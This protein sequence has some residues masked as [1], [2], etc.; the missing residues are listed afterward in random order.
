[1][2]RQ[3][4]SADA[5]RQLLVE[6]REFWDK[7]GDSR[8]VLQTFHPA[9]V[10]SDAPHPELGKDEENVLCR[11]QLPST[12]EYEYFDDVT[13][14]WVLIHSVDCPP[15]SIIS[16][17]ELCSRAGAG[18]P[19]TYTARMRPF[20]VRGLHADASSVSRWIGLLVFLKGLVDTPLA[21]EAWKRKHPD[22]QPPREVSHYLGESVTDSIRMIEAFRLHTDSP[23]SVGEWFP[24]ALEALK[25]HSR[26]AFDCVEQIRPGRNAEPSRQ[27]REQYVT[28][29]QMAA[30]ASR[31]KKTL[32]RWLKDGK[33]PEP[34]VEGGGGRPHEWRWRDVRD[35]LEE[36]SGKPMPERFPDVRQG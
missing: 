19:S 7:L 32:E 13:P 10:N 29:D 20:A 25:S 31:S 9:S 35:V 3:N 12:R 24:K 30:M 4:S 21:G 17:K 14:T 23:I 11:I 6:F 1:M 5:Y 36:Q 33:L 28:L 15:G 16:F 27:V 18:L 8:L 2:D 34:D 26:D 22:R